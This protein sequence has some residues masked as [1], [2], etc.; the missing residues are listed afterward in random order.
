MSLKTFVEQS[1]ISKIK[2]LLAKNSINQIFELACEYA[3]LDIIKLCLSSEYK[4]GIINI[5]RNNDHPFNLAIR[6]GDITVITF[7]LSLQ[8]KYG[9][10][11][12]SKSLYNA[13]YSNKLDIVK[14]V[15]SLQT[16]Y[17][18][19]DPNENII[20]ALYSNVEILKYVITIFPIDIHNFAFVNSDLEVLKFLI[21]LEQTHGKFDI[22]KCNDL[23]F[24]KNCGN[25]EYVIYLLSLEKSHG[26]FEIDINQAFCEACLK[27][28]LK[29]IKFFIHLSKTQNLNLHCNGSGC[30][31]QKKVH[32]IPFQN[33]CFSG[34]IDSVNFLLSL[35]DE[36]G[37]I[38]INY[39][40]ILENM[41]YKQNYDIVKLLLSF[42]NT[43]DVIDTNILNEAF[44]VS[45]WKK[46]NLPIVKLFTSLKEINIHLNDE[47]AFCNACDIGDFEL[48][49]YLLSLEKSHGLINIFASKESSWSNVFYS[50]L[51]NGNYDLAKFLL[52][53]EKDAK[54]DIFKKE[55]YVNIYLVNRIGNSYFNNE[56]IFIMACVWNVDIDMIK[57]L[58][59]IDQNNIDQYEKI[60]HKRNEINVKKVLFLIRILKNKNSIKK[61]IK[62]CNNCCKQTIEYISDNNNN[63]YCDTCFFKQNNLCLNY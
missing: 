52:N 40:D 62:F 3:K 34:N 8:N 20:Y 28:N 5:H 27:G 13:C 39:K 58:L 61:E 1:D 46:N 36:Y 9:T 26:K 48:I 60:C 2:S 30:E 12:L 47:K 31:C 19:I 59:D 23:I 25:L 54:F 56:T 14:L 63:F 45:C 24:Y 22:H 44:Q 7:L 43:T 53:L 41:C 51:D 50:A 32:N 57:F 42:H 49:N 55:K 21:S 4:Y 15:T 37:K 35:Q 10:F 29:C 33:A 17:N 6:S 38:T 18:K 11:N 16:Q